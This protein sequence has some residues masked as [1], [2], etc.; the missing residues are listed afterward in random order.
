MT[1][2]IQEQM[3]QEPVGGKP[4]ADRDLEIHVNGSR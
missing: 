4:A 3:S 2:S 1:P